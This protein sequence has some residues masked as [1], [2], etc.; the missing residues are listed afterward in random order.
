MIVGDYVEDYEAMVPFQT[1]LCVGHKVDVVS[2]GRKSG[3]TVKTAVHDFLPGDQTYTELRGHNFALNYDFGSVKVADYDALVI[4]GG[5]APE[6]LRNEARVIEIVREFHDAKKPIAAI[7]HGPQILFAA[8]ITKGR[9][10]TAYPAL[11]ADVE[12]SGGQWDA[13]CKID[14][15]TVSEDG[16]LITGQAWPGHPAWVRALLD[17]LG[18]KIQL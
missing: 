17:A 2:P 1:L 12:M 6:F 9:K 7:C 15:V 13:N 5:R 18:T 8:G 4:P 10:S 16:L 3:E 14:G 11:K